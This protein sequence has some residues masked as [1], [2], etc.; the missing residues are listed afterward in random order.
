MKIDENG[1]VIYSCDDCGSSGLKLWRDYNAFLNHQTLTCVPCLMKSFDPSKDRSELDEYRVLDDSGNFTFS[2]G[3]E[4]NGKI[5]AMLTEEGDTFYGFTSVSDASYRSWC[6]LPTYLNNP[7]L[8][9]LC[10]RNLMLRSLDNCSYARRRQRESDDEIVQLR[11]KHE[12]GIYCLKTAGV[13][14][15]WTIKNQQVFDTDGTTSLGWVRSGD[16]EKTELPANSLFIL[17][18]SYIFLSNRCEDARSPCSDLVGDYNERRAV[19]LDP[20]D[21]LAGGFYQIRK[22]LRGGNR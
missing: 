8:E 19:E 14:S 22:P 20:E 4:I 3:T 10:N 17:S 12:T 16:W 9:S 7:E 1:K 15:V 11:W 21:L 2:G 6:A 5:P 13:F 18:H